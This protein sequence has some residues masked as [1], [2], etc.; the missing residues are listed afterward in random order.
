MGFTSEAILWRTRR[1]SSAWGLSLR[2]VKD[3]MKMSGMREEGED[4]MGEEERTAGA[5]RKGELQSAE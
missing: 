4:E 5:S 2:W 1:A 3:L